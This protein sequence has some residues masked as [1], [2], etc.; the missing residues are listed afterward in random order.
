MG[1]SDQVDFSEFCSKRKENPIFFLG[2]I[3]KETGNRFPDLSLVIDVAC[4]F[5]GGIRPFTT[6][7]SCGVLAENS[8]C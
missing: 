7:T 5:P 2:L 1:G 4:I 8:R 6:P 3:A